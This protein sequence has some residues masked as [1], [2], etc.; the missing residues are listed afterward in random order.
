MARL[1]ERDEGVKA[2]ILSTLQRLLAKLTE[3]SKAMEAST[4]DQCISIVNAKVSKLVKTGLKELGGKN[5][6]SRIKLCHINLLKS[7]EPFLE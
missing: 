6:S 4:R 2:E 5:T 3:V 1:K 7:I